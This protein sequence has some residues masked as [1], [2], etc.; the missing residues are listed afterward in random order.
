MKSQTGT[1]RSRRL[2]VCFL[3]HQS[4]KEPYVSFAAQSVLEQDLVNVCGLRGA[5]PE[6]MQWTLQGWQ[7]T[8]SSTRAQESRLTLYASIY[9]TSIQLLEINLYV[10]LN[11][12]SKSSYLG[13]KCYRN[14]NEKRLLNQLCWLTLNKLTCFSFIIS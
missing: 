7:R 9:T 4:L 13:N 12:I 3:N 11:I 6:H 14:H 10:R 1:F 2:E 5:Q 8:L